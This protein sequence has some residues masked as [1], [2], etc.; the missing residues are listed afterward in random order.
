MKTQVSS[1]MLLAWIVSTLFA[2]RQS[3]Y[4]P[5]ASRHQLRSLLLLLSSPCSTMTLQTISSIGT[6]PQCGH[7]NDIVKEPASVIASRTHLFNVLTTHALRLLSSSSVDQSPPC[8]AFIACLMSWMPTNGWFRSAGACPAPLAL[9]VVSHASP[10]TTAP[11][12]F[13]NNF[14]AL[15]LC[16]WKVQITSK[17]IQVHTSID[18]H[19]ASRPLLLL[20]LLHRLIGTVRFPFLRLEEALLAQVHGVLL[21]LVLDLH[22]EQEEVLVR[23]LWSTGPVTATEPLHVRCGGPSYPLLHFFFCDLFL[24]WCLPIHFFSAHI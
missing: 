20:V 17:V 7:T 12:A 23:T 2:S 24:T 1:D 6:R 3:Y 8:S 21:I 19:R 18:L 16:C 5:H 14:F 10:R 13:A 4:P 11:A 9:S 22:R 15:T